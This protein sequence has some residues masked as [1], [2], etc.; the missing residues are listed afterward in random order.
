LLAYD[1][2]RRTTDI[3]I[4]MALGAQRSA[5]ISAVV[6]DAVRLIAFGVLAGMPMAWAGSRAVRSMLFGLTPTDPATMGAA[7]IV[8]LAA[9]RQV[10]GEHA[11]RASRLDPM[12]ALRHE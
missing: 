3:G 7:A 1:V 2:A 9:G 8:L 5:V 12:V 10:C 11:R 6:K 4:R